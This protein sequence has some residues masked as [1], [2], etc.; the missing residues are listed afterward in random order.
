MSKQQPYLDHENPLT[1][2]QFAALAED[3]GEL[4]IAPATRERIAAAAELVSNLASQGAEIYGLTTGFGPLVE[5][6][7]GEDND[8]HQQNLIFHLATGT[9]DPL[10]AAVVRGIIIHRLLTFTHGASGASLELV[11]YLCTLLHRRIEPHVPAYGSVGASGDLTPLAH[12]ALAMMGKGAFIQGPAQRVLDILE[13]PPFTFQKRDA[14]A[15]VNGTSASTS[16][17]ILAWDGVTRLVAGGIVSMARMGRALRVPQQAYDEELHVLRGHPGQIAVANALRNLMA[18]PEQ[19]LPHESSQALQ[20]AYSFRC[21]PQILGPVID[22]LNYSGAILQRELNGV[23]DN[24]VFSTGEKRAIHGG[25]FHGMSITFAV[26]SIF[27]AMATFAHLMERQI[28]RVTDPLLNGDLSPFLTG[29]EPG[30]NSGLMGL[31]VS[32]TALSAEISSAAGARYALESRSTNGANQDVVSMST[33]AGYR[34]YQ[35]VARLE[36]IVAMHCITSAQASELAGLD[37]DDFQAWVRRRSESLIT[38]RPLTEDI[39]TIADALTRETP[40]Q[41]EE[42]WLSLFTP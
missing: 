31:Q 4:R 11:D 29:A 21:I 13:I 37:T 12:V 38:D 27:L 10:P 20:T 6:F 28:A 34:A 24:P 18:G 35:T 25:N 9:G 15:L 16:M 32:A 22:A 40:L 5:Y 19:P 17:A 42:L 23:T 14:L 30:Q 41:W 39:R 26:D 1:L 33:L 3:P 36:E 2:R 7:S 8:V